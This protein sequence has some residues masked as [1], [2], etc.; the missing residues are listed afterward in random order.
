M[1]PVHHQTAWNLSCLLLAIFVNVHYSM[2]LE[3]PEDVYSNTWVIEVT[4][5]HPDTIKR[6]SADL[7]LHYHGPVG[8]MDNH[9]VV[10]HR[11]LKSGQN[12]TSDIHHKIITSHRN[13]KFA[14]QEKI[15]SR[16][17]R[18][19]D[20]SV[21]ASAYSSDGGSDPDFKQQWYLKNTGETLNFRHLDGGLREKQKGNYICRNTMFFYIS[22]AD[23]LLTM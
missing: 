9:H 5:D 2:L 7:F 12:R 14:Q 19:G 16:K 15:L 1:K 17:K 4:D 20:D 18:G 8:G 21:K 22:F 10:Q 11:T 3:Q 6:V 13:V 23:S